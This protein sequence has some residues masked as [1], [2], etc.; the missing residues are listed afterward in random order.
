MNLEQIA[1]FLKRPGEAKTDTFKK[2]DGAL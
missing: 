2:E 1:W